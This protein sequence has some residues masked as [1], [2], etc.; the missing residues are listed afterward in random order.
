MY[1]VALWKKCRSAVS[2]RFPAPFASRGAKPGHS[3]IS[4]RGVAT[5][6]KQATR[7]GQRAVQKG[8]SPPGSRGTTGLAGWGSSGGYVHT[9][10]HTYN[11]IYIHICV[12]E[13]N[14]YNVL[15]YICVYIYS[16]TW[17][18]CSWVVH[19]DCWI[20]KEQRGRKKNRKLPNKHEINM[21]T[22]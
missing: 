8:K 5:K 11:Y 22:I 17:M 2:P 1:E 9:V 10:I 6:V 7:K 12:C 4:S 3:R 13:Y 15:L 14:G 21:S 20:S 18:G 19:G 16:F